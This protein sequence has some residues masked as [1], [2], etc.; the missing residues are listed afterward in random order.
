MKRGAVKFDYD[1]VRSVD[2]TEIKL[3]GLSIGISDHSLKVICFKGIHVSHILDFRRQSRHTTQRRC[4][5]SRTLSC[6]AGQRAMHDKVIFPQK[7]E[8][9]QGS[10]GLSMSLNLSMLQPASAS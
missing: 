9:A 2:S 10:V 8:S 1:Q 6:S 7:S 3:H 4:I 5:V